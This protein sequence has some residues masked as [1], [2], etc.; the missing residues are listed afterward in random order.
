MGSG[1]KQAAGL[2]IHYYTFTN[3]N[4]ACY[5]NIFAEFHVRSHKHNCAC[6]NRPEPKPLIALT[7]LR[8]KE[9]LNCGFLRPTWPNVVFTELRCTVKH[10][11]RHVNTARFTAESGDVRRTHAPGVVNLASLALAHNS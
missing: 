10:P 11:S 6:G 4:V 5:D 1:L 9:K 3:V 8:L 2:R 7:S